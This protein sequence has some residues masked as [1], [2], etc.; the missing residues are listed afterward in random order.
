MIKT[1]YLGKTIPF[2]EHLVNDRRGNAAK[3][4]RLA[5]AAAQPRTR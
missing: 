1:Q 5:G 4:N 2:G 3:V